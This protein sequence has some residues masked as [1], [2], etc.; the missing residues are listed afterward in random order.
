MLLALGAGDF[1]QGLLVDHGRAAQQGTR[2][3]DVVFARELP[4]Q[5]ARRIRQQRQPFGEI[6]ARG[7]FGVRHKADQ[8]AVKEVD[9]LGAEIR[10]PLQKQIRDPPRRVGTAFRIVTSDD[11]FKS[12]D[13]RCRS[14]HLLNSEPA[15]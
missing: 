8:H 2:D 13:Q 9:M 6:G 3:R 7:D 12:G 1:D 14:G 15:G 4:D 10:S 5:A 11:L